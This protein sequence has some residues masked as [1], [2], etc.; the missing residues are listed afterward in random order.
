MIF[1]FIQLL[2]TVFDIPG[3]TCTDIASMLNKY[4]GMFEITNVMQNLN[5]FDVL[6]CF[7]LPSDIGNH[8]VNK[9]S[10][11]E[12]SKPSFSEEFLLQLKEGAEGQFARLGK[13]RCT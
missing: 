8:L 12:S 1:L 5:V 3:A 9:S 13:Y 11:E 10:K 7:K 2:Q 6:Q 4:Y